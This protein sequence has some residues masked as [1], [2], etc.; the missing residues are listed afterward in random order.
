MGVKYTPSLKLG[1]S[2]PKF[3][4]HIG[5]D[6]RVPDKVSTPAEIAQ[7][8]LQFRDGD[9]VAMQQ[10]V[11]TI[12]EGLIVAKKAALA[13]VA[14]A[15]PQSSVLPTQESERDLKEKRE[16]SPEEAEQT[17][18]S[19]LTRSRQKQYENL[20]P[21]IDWARAERALKATPEALWSAHKAEQSGHEPVVY[22]ADETG[23]KIGSNL[24]MESPRSTRNYVGHKQ[25]AEWLKENSP[26]ERF[27]GDAETQAEGIGMDLMTIEEGTHFA[28][29]TPAFYE[30]GW[31]YYRTPDHIKGIGYPDGPGSALYGAR[32][33]SDLFANRTYAGNHRDRGGW[34]G[35][36]RVNF[37]D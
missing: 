25:A 29:N 11:L 8:K 35:S 20:C 7:A 32:N 2:N 9:N 36:L 3:M 16:L 1:I 12:M 5:P 33:G 15:S 23:F 22:F 18:Q 4:P 30:Q 14:T 26:E 19:L 13:P 34:G 24:C 27:D 37:V 10:E 28:K 17:L 31:R 21:S 6:R